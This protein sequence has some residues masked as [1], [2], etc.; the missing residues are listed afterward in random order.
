MKKILIVILS[1]IVLYSCDQFNS[2]ADN[3]DYF[4]WQKAGI[5]LDENTVEPYAIV[6]QLVGAQKSAAT[7]IEFEVIETN[8]VEGVD[9][10]F[11][12]GKSLTIDANK[13]TASIEIQLIDNDDFTEVVRSIALKLTSA[14]G[15]STG[16]EEAPKKMY[17]VTILED[18]CPVPSLVGQYN[19]VTTNTSP[20]GCDGITNTVIIVENGPNSYTLSDI[21]GGI[22]KNCYLETDN[23]GDITFDGMN[24]SLVDQPDLVYP[25]DMFNGSGV[26]ACDGSFTLTFSNGFG[27]SGTSTFTQ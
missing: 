9:Y 12:N 23:P 18:D 21:T 5:S 4:Q 20:A 22:Y 7:A 8:V 13:S 10:T 26:M 17:T 25:P 19:V 2:V 14:G 6:I 1:T 15:L 3:E 16:S 24:I 27:D 11:P